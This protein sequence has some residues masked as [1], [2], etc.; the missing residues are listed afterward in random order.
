MICVCGSELCD[1]YWDTDG[2]E[3]ESYTCKNEKCERV[4]RVDIT[5]N[6]DDFDLDIDRHWNTITEEIK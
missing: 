6:S 5:R 2:I 1:S 3:W 4:Y